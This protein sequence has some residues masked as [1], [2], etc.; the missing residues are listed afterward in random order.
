MLPATP[1]PRPPYAASLSQKKIRQRNEVDS[2]E[3]VAMKDQMNVKHE[4]EVER[5]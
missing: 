5:R 2:N 3:R 1:R 4:I